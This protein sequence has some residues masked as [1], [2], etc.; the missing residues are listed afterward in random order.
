MDNL[1]SILKM[2][3]LNFEV[4][5]VILRHVQNWATAFEGRHILSYVEQ[6]Y[7]TLKAEGTVYIM[8][9]CC[10]LFTQL[11]QVSHSRLEMWL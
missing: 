2:P 4:K 5:N 8:L 7:R 10:A 9:S 1:V 11:L 3:A 6:V